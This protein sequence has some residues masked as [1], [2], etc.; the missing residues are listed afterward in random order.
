VK[1]QRTENPV[2]NNFTQNFAV[3]GGSHSWNCIKIGHSINSS[4]PYQNNIDELQAFEIASRKYQ[5]FKLQTQ[6]V[7]IPVS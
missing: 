3:S 7:V 2:K 5:C 6:M 1:V 4:L